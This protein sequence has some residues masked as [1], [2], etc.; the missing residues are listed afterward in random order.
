MMESENW[1]YVWL[2]L[3]QRRIAGF[4]PIYL[5]LFKVS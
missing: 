5:V 1:H 3:K 4:K 2:F